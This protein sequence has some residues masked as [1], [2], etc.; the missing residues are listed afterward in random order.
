M[1]ASVPGQPSIS[2]DSL[3]E[4]PGPEPVKSFTLTAQV[5]QVQGQQVWTYNGAIPGPELRVK[6][7][8]RVRVTLV[9]R[10]PTSTTIHWHGL[11]LPNAEDGVAGITQDA[12]QP[13]DAFTYEFVVRDPGRCWDA[14]YADTQQQVA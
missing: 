11:R 6:E 5:A 9:N 10:L 13:G 14:S 4:P 12:V 2:M 8:D 1:S 7:G 3:K